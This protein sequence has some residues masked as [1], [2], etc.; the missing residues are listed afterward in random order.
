MK[1]FIFV[2]GIAILGCE[3]KQKTDF[4][5]DEDFIKKEIIEFHRVLK[6]AYN[7]ASIDTDSLYDVYFDKDSYY[8]APWG[9]SE[10]IDSTCCRR[11]DARAAWC[12][13]RSIQLCERSSSMITRGP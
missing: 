10:P 1:T 2:L 11:A 12:C 5:Q 4:A 8:V 7:G 13:T 6:R 9:T 3:S